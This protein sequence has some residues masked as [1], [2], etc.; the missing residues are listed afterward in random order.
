MVAVETCSKAVQK[1]CIFVITQK[2]NKTAKRDEMRRS[3]LRIWSSH[4][5]VDDVVSYRSGAP[6]RISKLQPLLYGF[7]QGSVL[8]PLLCNMYTT[9]ISNVV[10]SHSDEFGLRSV[11]ELLITS[12][13]YAFKL[14]SN[15]VVVKISFVKCVDNQCQSQWSDFQLDCDH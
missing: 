3:K 6:S 4:L 7:P 8:G 5:A 13:S 2:C 1:G 10:E 11:V 9:D 12:V 14:T 15:C